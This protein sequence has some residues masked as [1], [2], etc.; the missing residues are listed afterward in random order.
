METSSFREFKKSMSSSSNN[1]RLQ[2]NEQE[3]KM[4]EAGIKMTRIKVIKYLIRKI[5][6]KKCKN[7]TLR[8]GMQRH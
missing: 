8:I 2:N 6:L 7:G 5:Y 4:M 1:R 3:R